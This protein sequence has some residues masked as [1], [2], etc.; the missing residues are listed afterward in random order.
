VGAAVHD[1]RIPTVRIPTVLHS[2][3]R[4]CAHASV[5]CCLP[6]QLH[7]SRGMM[8]VASQRRPLARLALAV[9]AMP[10]ALRRCLI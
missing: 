7:S 2:S 9:T 1:L 5:C 10:C 6:A 8:A 4:C 3:R